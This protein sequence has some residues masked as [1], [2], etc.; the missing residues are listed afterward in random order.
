MAF[1]HYFH[2]SISVV[3]FYADTTT[4]TL[5]CKQRYDNVWGLNTNQSIPWDMWIPTQETVECHG[6]LTYCG[7]D[8]WPPFSIR[9]FQMHF[10]EWKWMN[11]IKIQD[12]YSWRSNQQYPSVGS[13]TMM[14]NLLTHIC[15]IRLQW[16]NVTLIMKTMLCCNHKWEMAVIIDLDFYTQIHTHT[17]IYIY[18][19]ITLGYLTW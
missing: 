2:I 1:T 5:T 12:F 14:V 19:Y 18:I 11:S 8:K 6:E 3:V 10:L 13:D 7:R 4:S 9:H 15:A 16:V 17:Y